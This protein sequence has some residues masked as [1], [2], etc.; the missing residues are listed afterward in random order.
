[1]QMDR[2]EGLMS[3][4]FGREE[5]STASFHFPLTA[6]DGDG[7][8]V[9]RSSHEALNCQCCFSAGLV[10]L[11]YSKPH[12]Y[13]FV[14]IRL[15]HFFQVFI[16][17]YIISSLDLISH[18]SS[19]FV[20][21]NHLDLLIRLRHWPNDSQGTHNVAWHQIS[22][23]LPM[24]SRISMYDSLCYVYLT[25]LSIRLQQVVSPRLFYFSFPI[26]LIFSSMFNAS[27]R[28]CPIRA[29]FLL[30]PFSS[31]HGFCRFSLVSRVTTACFSS[32]CLRRLETFDQSSERE[33][34]WTILAFTESLW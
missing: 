30:L 26:L 23:H 17:F 3:L 7:N 33:E 25:A 20:V 13:L 6:N 31:H 22:D 18:P 24:R 8:R 27:R 10:S 12:S 14:Y 29:F 15:R 9:A 5:H 19:L 1:M 4:S 2:G 32:S 28:W 34:H 11:I 21:S 16:L